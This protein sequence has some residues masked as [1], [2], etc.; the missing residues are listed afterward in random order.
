[1]G[2][3]LRGFCFHFCI[4]L[5]FT[6]NSDGKESTCNAGDLG[7]TPGLGRSTGGGS[8][9]GAQAGAGRIGLHSCRGVIPEAGDQWW[10]CHLLILS[11]HATEWEQSPSQ[12]S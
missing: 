8:R 7:L 12:Q 1:M 10:G 5:G 6:G 3:I 11:S 4:F 9:V 2:S